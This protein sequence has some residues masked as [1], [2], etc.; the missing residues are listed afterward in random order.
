MA[1]DVKDVFESYTNLKQITFY[2]H[3]TPGRAWFGRSSFG[4]HEVLVSFNPR[5]ALF[6]PGEGRVLFA[7]C[8]VGDREAG[9]VFLICVG[10]KLLRGHGG[11]VGASKNKTFFSKWFEMRQSGFSDLQLFRLD[12]SG[13][14]VAEKVI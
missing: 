10:Q 9:R 4:S 8:N 14:V 6:A 13:N 5:P 12:A 3:G 11:I 2:T 7:G 1:Q